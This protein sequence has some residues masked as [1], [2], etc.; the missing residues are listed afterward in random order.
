MARVRWIGITQANPLFSVLD[1][2]QM[3]YRN[4]KEREREVGAIVERLQSKVVDR[5]APLNAT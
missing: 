1:S 2:L 4:S 3:A 5:V